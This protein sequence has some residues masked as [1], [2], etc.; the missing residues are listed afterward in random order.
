MKYALVFGLFGVYLAVLGVLLGGAGW[1]LLWPALAFGLVGAGFAGLGPRV[2][3]KR[4]NGRLAAWAVLLLLPYLALTWVVWHL[5]R[6]LSREPCCH[7]VAPG[8]WVG[9]RALAREL[10]E[11]VSL[12]VDLTAEFPEP[13]GVLRGRSYLCLPTLDTTAPEQAAFV[14]LIERLKGH[15]GGIYVHCASGHGRSATVAAGLLL[16]R[17][18]ARD[19][20]EA[21]Q[22]LRRAR[23]GIRLKKAQRAL[24][25]GCWGAPPAP[26]PADP[27]S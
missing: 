6:L 23:P 27:R 7:E 17:G 18:L 19:A 2:F 13:R 24:L 5:L 9:R 11:G 21:E 3:G 1:L 26:C 4:A 22:I 15:A 10:P 16:A 8:V 14:S 20:R 12:V 25:Q